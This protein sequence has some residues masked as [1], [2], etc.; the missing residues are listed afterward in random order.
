[1]V[2]VEEILDLDR[3]SAVQSRIIW[4]ARISWAFVA[5]EIILISFTLP[6][7]TRIFGLNEIQKGL[8][9]SAVLI[10]DVIGAAFFGRISDVIGRRPVFQISLLWYS[11]FTALTALSTG[12][13]D[14]LAYRLLAGVGLGGMLVVDPALLS[15]FLPP[16]R[17]GMLMVSLDLFWPVGSLVA[18]GF[19]YVFLELGGGNWRFLFLAAAFPAFTIALFR[20][21]VP[22]SPYY[23]AKRGDLARASDILRRLTGRD[24]RPESIEFA[25]EER[26]SYEELFTKYR[27]RALAML[28]A[29]ASLNYTYYGLF[30][31]LP[32]V[33][34]VA[35]L[36]G[37][38][39]LYLAL[40]FIL[41]IPGYASAMILVERWGRKKT[42]VL[43]LLMSGITG[44]VMA[45]ATRDA[46]IFTLAL[47]MVSFFNLGA[48]GSVYPFTS[49]LFPTKLRGKAFGIAE[50]FGKI[51]AVLGP[52]IF[53]ALFQITGSVEAPLLV[54][55]IIAVIGSIA[56]QI[57]APE[58]KGM[59]FD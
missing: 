6:I 53:G 48:W 40:A 24:V 18:L 38:I 46:M 35:S 4:I 49:E 54:T 57:L 32:E 23:L 12:F 30:L 13:Y 21:Y 55:M 17:R 56:I 59:I 26:G 10:G 43:Y 28:F 19:A 1:M 27:G 7:F 51:I 22:E 37:N 34:G 47:L 45:I 5:M 42:L 15:E 39:W 20:L 33:L 14:L 2:R 8:L 41:Q 3:I 29:W 11:I 9:A 44:I 52:I 16:R 31:W 36:Y 50:G 58:T 25:I